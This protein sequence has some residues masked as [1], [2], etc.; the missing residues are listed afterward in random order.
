M[1]SI[2]RSWPGA[3]SAAEAE[4]AIY[5]WHD[6]TGR[7]SLSDNAEMGL[8]TAVH[9][10]GLQPV[11][12]GY[13]K[14]P[15]NLPNGVEHRDANTILPFEE[16]V[17]HR[18]S[19]DH[20]VVADLAR[21]RGMRAAV[22]AG[23]TYVWFVD[24]DTLWC[25]DVNAACSLLHA[26]AFEHVVATIQGPRI[27]RSG[28]WKAIQ[29]GMVEFLRTP[30]DYQYTATPIRM[31]RR[32][33]LLPALLTAMENVM[34]ARSQS[35]NYLVFMDM[36]RDKVRECGLMGAY[37]DPTAFA[38]VPY[39]S[40]RSCLTKVR[41]NTYCNGYH[42]AVCAE[43]VVR[44]AIGL[45]SYW[46]SGKGSDEPLFERG[47]DAHVQHGS[48]W[49]GVL[50][51]LNAIMTTACSHDGQTVDAD[52]D[53]QASS[54]SDHGPAR[55]RIR[56]K[57]H[58]PCAPVQNPLP[59]SAVEPHPESHVGEFRAVRGSRPACAEWERSDI[60]RRCSL[61]RRL[62]EG[63]YGRVFIGK[64]E[65][66]AREVAVN[67]SKAQRLHKPIPPT[68]I[69]ILN[70]MQGHENVVSVRD[71]FFSPYFVVLVLQELSTDL[72]HL[73]RH[74][75]ENGG[76]QPAVAIRIT[77]LVARGTA[78]VHRKNIIHRDL[79]AGNILL[80]F[81]G[82]LQ[83]AVEV[84]LQP[85][86][87]VD[88]VCVADFG[89][90]CD[91][92][93]TKQFEKRSVGVGAR[94]ITPP[95]CYFAIKGMTNKPAT[96]DSAVDVWA[97]GVNLLLMIA[98]T[99][100]DMRF[101][102]AAQYVQ[103]WADILGKIPTSLATRMGWVLPS[104]QLQSDRRAMDPAADR[105]PRDGL[106]PG[107]ALQPVALSAQEKKS[108]PLQTTWMCSMHRAMLTYNGDADRGYHGFSR[109]IN[110]H[111]GIIAQLNKFY[112]CQFVM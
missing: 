35:G 77:S 41:V 91:V 12:Y 92:H 74:L 107:V 86:D 45:N 27:T 71:Y 37:T 36:L 69:A 76:L 61:I 6:E 68:E 72:W 15:V 25:K 38:A 5:W 102:R 14:P 17:R 49:A 70:R 29:N 108:M 30:F 109:V 28:V 8:R 93:G 20:A 83:S 64:Y 60:K 43:E 99:Q 34:A 96:Y 106:Q 103:F 50:Q 57:T 110:Y 78:H 18:K 31:T 9:I 2:A 33:P 104:T 10:A 52:Q 1:L 88:R 63:T 82:G 21:L 75:T 13:G 48:L 73:L 3:L 59:W 53:A 24:L 26:A 90:S 7:D 100:Q 40:K 67:I 79:H 66:E 84:G 94:A 19:Y 98:G 23:A 85:A 51:R 22:D 58:D 80:S 112:M 111:C 42:K 62:G 55:R 97:T 87:I 32:S 46:Q 16:F 89:Q 39:Y 101:D 56:D 95:E 11:L 81:K 105:P 4:V 47:S 65:G 54:Q 44:N